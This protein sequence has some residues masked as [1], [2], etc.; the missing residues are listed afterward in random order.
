MERVRIGVVGTSWWV[1]EMHLPNLRSHPQADVVAICGRNRERAELMAQ[2][3]AVPAI[4]ADYREMIATAELDALVVATPDDLHY[5]VAMAA[6]EAGLHVLCEKPLSL[7]AEE[8]PA[9]AAKAAEQGVKTLVFFTLRGLPAH[10]AIKELL[11]QGYIGRCYHCH[12]QH[13]IGYGRSGRWGGASI[14]SAHWVR[15]ATSALMRLIWRTG[16]SGGL[17]RSAR[18]WG[19]SSRG[20]TPRMCRSSRPGMPRSSPSVLRTARRASFMSARSGWSENAAFSSR[21]R[22]TANTVRSKRAFP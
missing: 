13:F 20:A 16:M 12:I 14:R 5:P 10:R 4:F 11:D 17:R 19:I 7:R 9:L 8:A 1:D 15:S 22:C 6:L 21:S 2:K 18:S 3:Y